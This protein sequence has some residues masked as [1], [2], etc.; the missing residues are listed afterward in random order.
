MMKWLGTQLWKAAVWADKKFCVKWHCLAF[1]I[2]FAAPVL[3]LS[4]VAVGQLGVWGWAAGPAMWLHPGLRYKA[5]GL[6]VRLFW[7]CRW[8]EW[9][10]HVGMANASGLRAIETD[11]RYVVRLVWKPGDFDFK[12]EQFADVVKI[13]FNAETVA[14][15]T[16]DGNLI[17]VLLDYSCLPT[18]LPVEVSDLS[19]SP[20]LAR[21]GV[22]EGDTEMVWN[23]DDAPHL[24]I[25]GATGG[26][27]GGVLKVILFHVLNHPESW[28]PPVV[29]SAKPTGE[30]AWLGD[31]GK[32]LTPKVATNSEGKKGIDCSHM[33]SEFVKYQNLALERGI[34]IQNRGLDK[35]DGQR[36]LLVVDECGSLLDGLWG[37]DLK[38]VVKAI[39]D[40]A[41]MGRSAGVHLI[42]MTQKPDVASVGGGDVLSN[43]QGRILVGGSSKTVEQTFDEKPSKPPSSIKGR[44]Q[45]H[46]LTADDRP[47]IS[48][49]VGW[50]PQKAPAD[51]LESIALPDSP[52]HEDEPVEE[53]EEEDE[54]EECECGECECGECE[55]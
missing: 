37:D 20:G 28:T 44:V 12:Y 50:I 25:F 31:R 1:A 32:F 26:G 34:E 27:K 40:I 47:P 11:G 43:L 38:T 49:Q 30:M 16:L 22:S 8:S 29:V 36:A 14:F 48:G 15:N 23:V 21:I 3:P 35:W 46:R 7:R 55:F 42:L 9:T 45:A 24:G 18:M 54:D 39:K 19:T 4:L 53:H 6:R 33:V 17:E 52:E 13:E 10:A 5:S 41:R 2:A 51:L